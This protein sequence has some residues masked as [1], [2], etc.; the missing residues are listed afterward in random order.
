MIT[1]SSITLPALLKV[2]PA[3]LFVELELPA[4]GW[5]GSPMAAWF[6]I[7]NRTCQLLEVELNLQASDAFMF[8]GQKQVNDL[9]TMLRV[10]TN[11]N[12]SIAQVEIDA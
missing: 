3:P 11:I 7:H 5:V 6:K 12:L 10:S 1:S 4:H 8:A 9:P 2:D